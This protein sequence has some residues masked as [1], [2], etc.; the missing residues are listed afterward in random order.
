[1]SSAP[2]ERHKSVWL[3]PIPGAAALVEL[4]VA[5]AVDVLFVVAPASPPMPLLEVDPLLRSLCDTEPVAARPPVDDE[6]RELV[7]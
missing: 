3:C 4:L 1:M 2:D 7:V 6:T 5:A